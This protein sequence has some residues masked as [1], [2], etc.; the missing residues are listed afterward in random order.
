LLI[1]LTAFLIGNVQ[2]QF[3]ADKDPFKTQSLSNSSIQKV[4]ARTSGGS[5][6]VSGVASGEARIEVFVRPNNYRENRMS[7]ED[8][9]KR[10]DEDYV[11]VISTDNN[12][13]TAT[14]KPKDR[15]FNWKRAL[16]I[17][18]Q[19]YVPQNNSTDLATS[20][21]SIHLD[22]LNGS[23]EFSTSGGS[24]HIDKL[25]GNIHGRTS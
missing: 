7:K 10:L 21:G 13:L 8:I 3:D 14:A 4:Y 17:S 1:L 9:Q 16:S 19:I 2:A 23:Q 6:M 18:F 12:K 15:D 24:L 25:T 5:I 20:G 22:N 11:L